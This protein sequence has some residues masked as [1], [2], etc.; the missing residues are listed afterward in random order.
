MQPVLE[1]EPAL[2]EAPPILAEDGVAG[3][4]LLPPLAVRRDRH[5]ERAREAR[6]LRARMIGDA[7]RRVSFRGPSIV[8]P[9]SVPCNTSPPRGRGEAGPLP[10]TSR[11]RVA[12]RAGGEL[13]E[14]EVHDRLG[15]PPRL[16]AHRG[17]DGRRGR[18]ALRV[19]ELVPGSEPDA[20]ELRG[21]HRQ[22][23]I[24]VAPRSAAPSSTAP[25][26]ACGS[27]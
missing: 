9:V 16:G 23:R 18:R 20:C 8:G 25:R 11:L 19:R 1:P 27:S 12:R 24:G 2:L 5:L 4:H 7:H 21:R 6:A 14:R 17:Q 3:V 15:V 22:E 13:L 26:S 10:S